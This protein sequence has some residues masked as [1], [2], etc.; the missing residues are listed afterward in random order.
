MALVEAMYLG[1]DA[2]TRSVMA[3]GPAAAGGWKYNIVSVCLFVCFFGSVTV[4]YSG[5]TMRAMSRAE[6]KARD[7]SAAQGFRGRGSMK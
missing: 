2:G 6:R 4:R 3:L 1:L 7:P 5:M